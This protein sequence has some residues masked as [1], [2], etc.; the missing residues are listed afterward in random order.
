MYIE[1]NA[2]PDK[3]GDF[4]PDRDRDLDLDWDLAGERRE[5]LAFGDLLQYSYKA[6]I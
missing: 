2:Y 1:N 3:E 5:D 6:S 4:D